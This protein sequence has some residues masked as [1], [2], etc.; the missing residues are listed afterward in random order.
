M[1]V[2]CVR[3]GRTA[4]DEDG[5]LA[6][7]VEVPL[8]DDG[9]RE[10]E[11]LVDKVRAAAPQ[12]LY[13]SEADPARAS[14]DILARALGLRCSRK[15]ELN[16]IGL[17]LWQG[18]LMDAIAQKHPKAFREWRANPVDILPPGAEPIDGA[19]TR[20]ESF[21]DAM[22]RR[23]GDENVLVVVPPLL[24]RLLT[25]VLT[26]RPFEDSMRPVPECDAPCSVIERDVSA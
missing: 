1:K 26:S 24:G 13:C 6:G 7:N 8:C 23:H 22:D 16:E 15:R 21:V 2:V 10:I 9:V 4:W 3:S 17:G 12:V 19:L 11:G 20:V 14:A 25:S 18:M 5:R